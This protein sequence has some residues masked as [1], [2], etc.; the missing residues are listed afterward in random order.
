MS[1]VVLVTTAAFA[2]VGASSVASA[3]TLGSAFTYQGTFADNGAPASGT[4]DFEFALYTVASGGTA[5]QTV[6]KAGVAVNGGLINTSIDFGAQTYNGQVKWVEVH[7]RPTGGGGYTTLSPRQ[8]LTAAPYAMGLPMPF[9]RVVNTGSA[10]SF[11][12]TNADGGNAIAG[13][14]GSASGFS[15]VTGSS[16]AGPGVNGDSTSSAGVRGTSVQSDGVRGL[17]TNGTGVHGVGSTGVW[18][19]GGLLATDNISCNSGGSCQ[20]VVNINNAAVGNMIIANA[21]GTDVFR[22]NGNGGVFAN[23]GFQASGADLAEHVPSAGRLEAGDVVEI[24]AENGG[25]FQLSSRSNSTAVA[26]V[27]STKPGVTLNGSMSEDEKARGLSRLALSGR[28]PVKATAE[29]GA[30]HAGDLLVSSSR[31][32]HAMRAPES[33][34]AGTVIGKAMQKLDSDSG[35]IEMLVMLR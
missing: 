17:S 6:T 30:I 22:V 5:V 26:G 33:P 20:S 27:I 10:A 28:V 12:I 16:P 9:Q 15:A 24:D 11:Q 7:V 18:A 8:A 29:N 1:T 35:E 25:A 21:A 32:G 2:S 3:Q 31:P 34:R 19:E 13:I 14:V 23:G 4:Y